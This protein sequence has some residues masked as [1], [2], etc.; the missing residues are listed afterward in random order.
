MKGKK[1]PQ[2][3]FPNGNDNNLYKIY[4]ENMYNKSEL[5]LPKRQVKHGPNIHKAK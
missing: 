2:F 1:P 5:S 4:S 3:K